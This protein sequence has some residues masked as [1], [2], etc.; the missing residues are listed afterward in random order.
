VNTD[1][2]GTV[3]GVP[4]RFVPDEMPGDLIEAEHLV[5]YW[6]A[7]ELAAGKAVLDAACGVGYGTR[8]LAAAGAREA[9]GL[10]IAEDVI[11]AANG[12]AVPGLR[13]VVGDV[14]EMPFEDATFDLITCFET[15]E[16]VSDPAAAIVELSRVLAP[17]GILVVSSPNPD[18]YVPGNPHH[19]HEFRADELRDLLLEHFPETAVRRQYGWVTSAILDDET[20]HELGLRVLPSM[21]AASVTDQRAGAEPYSLVV[22]S[23]QTIPPLP[24]RLVA[25]GLAEPRRWVERYEDQQRV[26]S[27]QWRKWREADVRRHDA[28]TRLAEVLDQADRRVAVVEE[29]NR[30]LK[31]LVRRADGVLADMRRSPSWRITAPLR[32]FKRLLR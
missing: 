22:A 32:A 21:Q 10:D 19:V 12:A 23:H 9:V 14:R 13:F 20:S 8:M 4:E 2:S 24:S 16:H 1:L 28:E 26:L 30:K 25:T 6:W 15:I 17:G 11:D 7:T 27:D 29:D 3:D 31:E 5:R 18:A